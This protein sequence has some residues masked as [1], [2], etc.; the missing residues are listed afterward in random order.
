MKLF[1]VSNNQYTRL[2]YSLFLTR[3]MKG[4]YVKRQTPIPGWSSI[5]QDTIYIPRLC[6]KI[7]KE[8]SISKLN[9]NWFSQIQ[10]VAKDHFKR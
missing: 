5:Y 3:N 1:Y 4:Y 9:S 6:T 2:I 7:N 10:I 8:G